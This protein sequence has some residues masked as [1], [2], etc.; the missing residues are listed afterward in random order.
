[1]YHSKLVVLG[2]GVNAAVIFQFPRNIPSSD[3]QSAAARG[4][5][6]ANLCVMPTHATH[7]REN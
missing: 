5:S 7:G 4:N 1:M 3:A 2:A 6:V